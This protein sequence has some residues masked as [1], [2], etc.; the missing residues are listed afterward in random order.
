M[1]QND[2]LCRH[3]MY[4]MRSFRFCAQCTRQRKDEQEDSCLCPYKGKYVYPDTDAAAC[5][6]F[7]LPIAH[8]RMW[9]NQ[10]EIVIDI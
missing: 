10:E 2:Y 5:E 4:N 6:G 7:F 8:D 9:D 1:W 3:N